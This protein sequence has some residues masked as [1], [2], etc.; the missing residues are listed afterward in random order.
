MFPDVVGCRTMRLITI[1]S[2]M[3]SPWS[4]R[5]TPS[6][7]GMPVRVIEQRDERGTASFSDLSGELGVANG[8]GVRRAAGTGDSTSGAGPNDE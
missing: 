6:S 2:T 8:L 3:S 1:R 4:L 7:A 5:C